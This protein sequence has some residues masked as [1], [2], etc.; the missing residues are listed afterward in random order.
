VVLKHLDGLQFHTREQL[1][2]VLDT[3]EAR[4][5]SDPDGGMPDG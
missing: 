5:L 3:T 1:N 2:R 4:P